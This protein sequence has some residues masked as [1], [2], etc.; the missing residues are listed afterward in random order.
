[1]IDWQKRCVC[2]NC[3]AT[4]GARDPVATYSLTLDRSGKTIT[5]CE[6]CLRD[7]LE[8]TKMVLEGGETKND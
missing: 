8:T 7:L 5:L 4:S 6:R 1:M 3:E 2:D